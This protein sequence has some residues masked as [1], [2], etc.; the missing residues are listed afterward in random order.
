MREE[1]GSSV[2]ILR[3]PQRVMTSSKIGH[4]KRNSFDGA[5]MINIYTQKR[6]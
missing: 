3:L 5:R 1:D 6:P 2:L 4:T